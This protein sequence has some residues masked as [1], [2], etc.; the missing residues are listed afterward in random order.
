MASWHEEVVTPEDR[1]LVQKARL[2]LNIIR[3]YL[4]Q[5]LPNIIDRIKGGS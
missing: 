4:C 2:E 1:W 3:K 5:V